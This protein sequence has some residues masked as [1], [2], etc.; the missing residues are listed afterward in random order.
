[1]PR[2]MRVCSAPGCPTLTPTGRCP[3]HRSDANQDRGSAASRGYGHR[4]ATRF[5]A[6][7]L[8]RDPLC[9]CPHPHVHGHGVR[10]YQPS[11]QA[12]HWPR[13]R[14]ELVRVGLDPNDPRY[15]RGLCQP[16]HAAITADL[17]PGG[18]NANARP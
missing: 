1:M 2:A 3:H 9:T 7:V 11:T 12:D 4:H 10:C 8:R 17:Q 15:G 18:W 5:R 16:C 13:E 6:P 14:Q